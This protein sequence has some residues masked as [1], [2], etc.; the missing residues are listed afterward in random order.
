MEG[1]L[2]W[3][4]L[5][6]LHFAKALLLLGRTVI[7]DLKSKTPLFEYSIELME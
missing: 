7:N 2:Y 4:S 6:D 1:V 5:L 3:V